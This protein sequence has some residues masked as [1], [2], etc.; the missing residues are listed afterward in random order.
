MPVVVDGACPTGGCMKPDH[1]L[2]DTEIDI[3]P[4]GAVS[5]PRI[6]VPPVDLYKTGG[7]FESKTPLSRGSGTSGST[8]GSGAPAT[9]GSGSGTQ[10]PTGSGT[11]PAWIASLSDTV[12]ETDMTA[13]A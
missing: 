3:G 10:A 8:P 1:S 13:A 4:S 7:G 9:G 11:V 5:A 12:I 2:N 6:I